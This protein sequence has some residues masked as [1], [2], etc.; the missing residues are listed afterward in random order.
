VVLKNFIKNIPTIGRAA[1]FE[2]H[3]SMTM[4]DFFA[5]FTEFIQ[6]SDEEWQAILDG[7]R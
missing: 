3:F 1:S 2:Q 4:E 5:A 7:I 6:G